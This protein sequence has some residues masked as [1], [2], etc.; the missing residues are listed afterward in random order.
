MELFL[1]VITTPRS[2]PRGGKATPIQNRYIVM[3]ESQAAA[4]ERAHEEMPG[5]I[6]ETDHVAVLPCGADNRVMRAA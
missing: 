1:L 6:V 3:A 5:Q 4:L 2:G